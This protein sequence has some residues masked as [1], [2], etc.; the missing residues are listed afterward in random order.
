[1]ECLVLTHS[2]SDCQAEDGSDKVAPGHWVPAQ[3]LVLCSVLPGRGPGLLL[4]TSRAE[5][6]VSVSPK[7]CSPATPEA[8]LQASLRSSASGP[9]LGLNGPASAPAGEQPCSF[10]SHQRQADLCFQVLLPSF[11]P[12]SLYLFIYLFIACAEDQNSPLFSALDVGGRMW[13]AMCVGGL[14]D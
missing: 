4:P 14:G 11:L 8:S 12:S 1:M 7:A 6:K 2:C 13:G 10:F 3:G 9:S 5:P